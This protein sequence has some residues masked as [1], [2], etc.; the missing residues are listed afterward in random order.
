MSRD[1]VRAVVPIK[2]FSAAK[3]RL[4]PV[5]TPE[6]R[7]DFASRMAGKVVQ[8]LLACPEISET[9]I[10]ASDP[11][12]RQLA[13]RLGARLCVLDRDAGVNAA[14]EAGFRQVRGG[15]ERVLILPSDLPL[16]SCGDFRRLLAAGP[17]KATLRIVADKEGRGTN[18]LLLPAE[19]EFQFR[20]GENSAA[21]H[22][23]VARKA[24]LEVEFME[25]PGLALDIDT[26]ADLDALHARGES[27][28]LALAGRRCTA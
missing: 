15:C 22:A 19:A 23:E 17:R 12:V 27:W 13:L 14:V 16:A 2:S 4:A 3:S 20:F 10:V 18:A 11:E 8:S 24:G 6:A 25:I 21:A 28:E 5:L 1:I 7:R 9:L 26:P